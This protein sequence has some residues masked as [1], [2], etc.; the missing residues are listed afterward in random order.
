MQRKRRSSFGLRFSSLVGNL[1]D[2]DHNRVFET[3][4]FQLLDFDV[5]YRK[6][7]EHANRVSKELAKV[8]G[9][10]TIVDY[11]DEPIITTFHTEMY[12]TIL[13]D[14]ED[15][16]PD[17]KQGYNELFDKVCQ[18][19]EHWKANPEEPPNDRIIGLIRHM[20]EVEDMLIYCLMNGEIL[21]SLDKLQFKKFCRPFLRQLYKMGAGQSDKKDTSP[22]VKQRQERFKDF[23]LHGVLV[24]MAKHLRMMASEILAGYP[25]EGLEKGPAV[26]TLVTQGS[27]IT[28][29]Q[30]AEKL[31]LVKAEGGLANTNR[32]SIAELDHLSPKDHSEISY[33]E[34]PVIDLLGNT[35]QQNVKQLRKEVHDQ[36]DLV[37]SYHLFLIGMVK[38]MPVRY[39]SDEF[40]QDYYKEY[41][42]DPAA[43]RESYLQKLYELPMVIDNEAPEEDPVM[44]RTDMILVF[45][46]AL[47]VQSLG[48]GLS[49]SSYLYTKYLNIQASISGVISASSS[50]GSLMFRFTWNYLTKFKSYRPTF[51]MWLLVTASGCI[52]YYFVQTTVDYNSKAVNVGGIIMLVL[53]RWLMGIGAARGSTRKYLAITVKPWAQSRFSAYYIL[54][55]CFANCIGAGIQAVIF[56]ADFGSTQCITMAGS[57]MCHHNMIAF[58]YI[59]VALVLWIFYA[60]FFTGYDKKKVL[61]EKNRKFK[62]IH[63]FKALHKLDLDSVVDLAVKK[64]GKK[65]KASDLKK[66]E[67]EPDLKR[68]QSAPELPDHDLET[69]EDQGRNPFT[70]EK[71]K[72]ERRNTEAAFLAGAYWLLQQKK[73]DPF[74]ELLEQNRLEELESTVKAKSLQTPEAGRR[75]SQP[76]VT[77]MKLQRMQSAYLPVAASNMDFHDRVKYLVYHPKL[78]MF[79]A[80]FVLFITK[81]G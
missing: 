30:D 31:P 55:V 17:F 72:L 10:T 40:Y 8:Y 46:N 51:L 75:D 79:Y 65:V 28:T 63:V 42:A 5:L 39:T 19:S 7:N 68:V 56:Y 2:K 6:A 43:N 67:A 54:A 20:R 14:V 73:N 47:M 45:I 59:F 70:K 29:Q 44:N 71:P 52:L 37:G 57:Q 58:I 66:L 12:K 16:Y 24:G 1:T 23:I 4:R 22:D 74:M 25:D 11:G 78:Y 34:N 53:S 61:A 41:M 48:S 60:I 13:A 35:L 33:N 50:L 27:D 3:M 9:E 77:E 38:R 49:V 36:D 32:T 64:A 62:H 15:K 69:Q 76:R 80:V 81:V 21:E 18:F 26:P